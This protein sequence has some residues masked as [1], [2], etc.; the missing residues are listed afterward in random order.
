MTASGQSDATSQKKIQKKLAIYPTYDLILAPSV[1]TPASTQ[2]GL[3]QLFSGKTW[4]L[5]DRV[6]GW[7]D[8]TDSCSPLPWS[9]DY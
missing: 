5:T 7:L 3:G 1:G 4:P 6:V 9:N 2:Q 8:P